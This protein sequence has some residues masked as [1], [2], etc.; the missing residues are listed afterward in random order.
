MK[1]DTEFC[2]HW[3]LIIKVHIKKYII[4]NYID[5]L[6]ILLSLEF[7]VVGFETQLRV[8][9]S[10]VWLMYCDAVIY[11]NQNPKSPSAIKYRYCGCHTDVSN[12]CARILSYVSHIGP[13]LLINVNINYYVSMLSE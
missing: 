12:V 11:I 1:N 10:W 2:S 3:L 6:F 8:F 4:E 7:I 5:R 9:A 13:N